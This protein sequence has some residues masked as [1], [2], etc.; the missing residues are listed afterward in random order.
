MTFDFLKLDK[1]D[2]DLNGWDKVGKKAINAE[3]KINY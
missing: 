1:W 2:W 3:I